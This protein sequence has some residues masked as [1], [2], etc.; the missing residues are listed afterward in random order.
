MGM[1]TLAL[2]F[3]GCSWNVLE[4]LL[5]TG[6]LP[7]LSALLETGSHGVL[8]STI[9]FYT[10]PAWASFA[11]GSSPA[12]HGVY[13][14]MM[15]RD[16]GT[17]SVARRDDL[18]R[19]TYYQQLGEEGKSSVLINLPIDQDGCEGAVIVNSWLT[20][21]GARRMLPMGKQARYSR[22]LSA[23]RTFPRDPADVDELCEIEQA[24]FDL[25]RELFLGE[26]WDH[27]FVLFSSTD[28][29][30]HQV[31][32]SVLS[33]DPDARR[34]M[35]RLY[36][37]LDGYVGWFVEHAQDA[38]VFIVS[39]HGQCEE[40]AVVRVNAV[41]HDLG[42]LSVQSTQ[43][44]QTDPFFVSKRN[45]PRAKIR[46]PARFGRHR[47][48]PVIRPVAVRLKRGLRKGFGLELTRASYAV[49]RGASRAF[50]PTDASF[51]IYARDADAEDLQRI[52]DALLSVSLPDGRPAI[53]LV[54]TPEELYGRP[55]PSGPALLFAP[56]HGVRASA[57][58]KDRVVDPARAP[59]RGCHQRD[60][61]LIVGG[62]HAV[63]GD[64]GR[65][66]IYDVMP[67]MLWSMAAGIPAAGDGRVLFEAFD[68]LLAAQPVREVD[69]GWLEADDTSSAYS[70]EV[71]R[72]LKAL[73]YI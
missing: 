66:S 37:R 71:V 32:G 68:E 4:P 67:T 3:D 39:D 19:K 70:D 5:E 51:A 26:S 48:N 53:E 43:P 31:A 60:G 29:I 10:G 47:M 52:R 24:R 69:G 14:F 15:L 57:M 54:G 64:L 13:D 33:G 25:A 55:D 27:F 73:G 42:L 16:D 23:Y 12:A 17:L 9:P 56:S 40:E 11:T 21:D 41:L 59:G 44:R 49:D 46:V 34:Q 22:L 1:R 30:G 35:L 50:S 45:K 7:N 63:Q 6:E 28:W 61:I 38:S 2:G 72:R 18:R 65:C 8:E 62:A 58:I 20:E 36:R